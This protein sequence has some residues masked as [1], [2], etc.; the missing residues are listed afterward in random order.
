M[1]PL[2]PRTTQYLKRCGYSDAQI[3]R[4]NGETRLFHD[5]GLFGDSAADELDI[6]AKEYDVDFSKFHFQKYFPV[7][8]GWDPF[9]L[10][11]LR[12]TSLAGRIRNR[13]P[14]VTFDMIEE[15]IAQKK[16]IFD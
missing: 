5:V 7:E 3:A 10:T 14:P 11:F 15:V 6:L 8:F 1:N 12:T 2:G 9:V 16:W 13:Y 4:F